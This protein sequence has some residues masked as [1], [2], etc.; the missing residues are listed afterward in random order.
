MAFI[1]DKE[2]EQKIE[3][4]VPRV[5]AHLSSYTLSVSATN[6]RGLSGVHL[7]EEGPEKRADIAISVIGVPTPLT[8]L[9]CSFVLGEENAA[10]LRRPVIFSLGT[11]C[12]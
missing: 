1:R 12:L 9:D 11:Y 6:Y 8:L 5:H 2:R 10:P 3:Q 4:Y 7:P